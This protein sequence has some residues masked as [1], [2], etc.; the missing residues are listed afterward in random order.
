MLEDQIAGC[1]IGTAVGDA[2]GLPYEGLSRHRARRLLGKPDRYR[3]LG[4][5]GMVS[6]DTEHAC[7]T[8]ESLLESKLD[9]TLFEKYLARRLRFWLLRLPAGIGRATLVSIL[10]LWLFVPPSRSGVNSAGNGP[11][12][13]AAI[14]GVCVQDRTHLRELVIISSRM[15]HSDPR[16]THGALAIALA[17]RHVVECKELNPER[18]LND[19]RDALGDDAEELLQRIELACESAARSESTSEFVESCNGRPGIS[20]YINDTVPA[21][22]HACFARHDNYSTAV[23]DIVACGGDTDTASAIAGGILGAAHGIERIPDAWQRNL[24]EWPCSINWMKTLAQKLASSL[25]DTS[26]A[27][28]QITIGHRSY[29]LIFGLSQF[30]RNMFF[31]V[32]V[33]Y[34]GFRRLLPPY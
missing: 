6:D 3:L 29:Q 11:A 12:M 10:K 19:L 34:H 4:H 20:G 17:A 21:A 27:S 13:R 31:L 5:F 2:I 23:Q 24:C 18:Y 32:I 9:P 15:T 28:T 30:A 7:L 1:L 14:L 16:A 33:L 25:P 8:A 26:V 22:L